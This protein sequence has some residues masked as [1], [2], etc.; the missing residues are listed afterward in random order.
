MERFLIPAGKSWGEGKLWGATILKNIHGI[1]SQKSLVWEV[2]DT[3]SW[4]DGTQG[5]SCSLQRKPRVCRKDSRKSFFLKG[6]DFCWTWQVELLLHCLVGHILE[7]GENGIFTLPERKTE[8]YR[9]LERMHSME[10]KIICAKIRAS[11]FYP[12][13]LSESLHVRALIIYISLRE[14]SEEGS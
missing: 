8:F 4:K 1:E 6:E 14:N 10:W 2:Y 3:S 5:V 7:R 11:L 12:G 9:N 13:R